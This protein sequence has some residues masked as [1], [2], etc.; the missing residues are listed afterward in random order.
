MAAENATTLLIS[1][2]ALGAIVWGYIRGRAFGKLGILAWLQSVLLMAPWLLFFGLFSLGIYLNVVAVLLLFVLA[3]VAYIY[4]GRQMRALGQN[5]LIRERLERMLETSEAE[6]AAEGEP[7]AQRSDGAE[8]QSTSEDA[9]KASDSSQAS[10]MM[11]PIPAEDLAAIKGIF[12]I[13][14]FFSTETIPYQEGAI[15]KGNLRGEPV[16]TLERLE[17]R[18]SEGLGDR[19]RVYLITG[20]EER[21]VVIVLP[22]RTEPK[23]ASKGQW[24]LA[25]AL[26]VATLITCLERAGLQYGFDIFSEPQRWSETLLMG[27]SLMSILVA[28]EAG[29]WFM[30]R[31]HSVRLGPSFLLPAWQLGSFGGLT[32]IESVLPNRSVLFDVAFAGP[33]AGGLLAFVFLLLGLGLSPQFGSL[34]L[35]AEILQGSLLVGTLARTFLG[36]TLQEATVQ[37][38]PFVIVGWLGLVITALNVL[39][40]GQLDGGRMIQAIYGRKMAGRT[41][42][43]SLVLLAIFALANPVALYWAVLVLFLQR[44]PERPSQNELTEPDDT[45]AALCLLLLFLTLVVLVPLSPAL[46]GRLGIGLENAPTLF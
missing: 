12:G 2:V 23:P 8:G 42:F 22:T 26:A 41:T 31:R 45:R 30:A 9:A 46:A 35:P 7:T 10:R 27:L 25:V 18:L 20:P 39:P 17:K 36:A 37:I 19:Y 13:D 43:I 24:I 29:H 34:A 6:K 16:A 14:T 33:A 3:T 32:R 1:L 4:I 44:Q 38:H 28:H 40:A 5:E 11:N 21:P 15:F